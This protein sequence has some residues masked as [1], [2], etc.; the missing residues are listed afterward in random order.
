[1]GKAGKVL[2]IV[3]AV[4]MTF[5]A[6]ALVGFEA[7][8]ILGKTNLESKSVTTAPI[9]EQSSAEA[10]T[11]DAQ[12]WESDWVRFGG[13]VYDY[14]E[15]IKT[16]LIMGIDKD[17]EVVKE[18]K[19]GMDGGQADALFLLV[20]NP[21]NESIKIIGINRNTMTDVDVY[22]EYGR[23]LTTVIAQVAVQHGFGN[24]LEESCEYQV[25]AVSNLFYQL[26][27]HGYAAVN[28][29]AIPILN[30]IVGGVDVTVLEDMTQFNSL[31]KEG[32]QVHLDGK[33]AFTYVQTRDTSVYGSSDRRLE[34]QR[35]YLNA[36]IKAARKASE[37]N[38]NAAIEMFSA[39]NSKMVTDISADE[40]S[41]LAPDMVRYSFDPT[42]FMMIDG[43]NVKG[44]EFEE[45][46]IDE[47]DLKRT[48]ID[49]FYEKVEDV[50]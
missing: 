11:A 49:V 3:W 17:D 29:S 25:K 37:E 5:V 1:M 47:D 6:G 9:L 38:T 28:M 24:G 42:D 39:I 44:E 40:I 23:Y 15:D 36:F 48:I 31:L 33:T 7:M 41:F 20:I 30:D 50:G 21:R 18:V 2:L 8:R 32:E 16:F 27:I 43:E 12:K 4:L 10:S 46:Y 26:P 14:N 19:E 22:D 35:Q 34:R 45:F 13:S